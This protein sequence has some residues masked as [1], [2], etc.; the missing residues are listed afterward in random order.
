[1]HPQATALERER[2]CLNPERE[3]PL[4]T[5]DVAGFVI[6]RSSSFAYLANKEVAG[7]RM[8]VRLAAEHGDP[9]K[10]GYLPYE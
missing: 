3:R 9:T 8:S 4:C 10:D 7:G 2:E 6:W 5:R 1:M